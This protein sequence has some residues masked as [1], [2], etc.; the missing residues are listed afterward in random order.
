MLQKQCGT[1]V[2]NLTNECKNLRRRFILDQ[3]VGIGAIPFISI[4]WIIFNSVVQ[5]LVEFCFI[6]P[7]PASFPSNF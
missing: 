4:E 7:F 5:S 1:N 3:D 2:S 6:F